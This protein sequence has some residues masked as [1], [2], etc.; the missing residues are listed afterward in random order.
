MISMI[1]E[2]NI[3]MK[4]LIKE[5]II[6]I[7]EPFRSLSDLGWLARSNF[8]SDRAS[9]DYQAVFDNKN[10]L[11]TVCIATYNR[12]ELLIER[13]LKS[14]IN[15]DYKN[16]QIVVVGDCCTDDTV[17]RMSKINDKRVEFVNLPERGSYP[18]EPRLRWMV[19]GTAAVNHALSMARGDFITHLDDDDEQPH[20]RISKLVAFARDKRADI[21][22][23]PFRYEKVPD[24]WH[25][26]SA[27]KFAV[28]QVTTSS[29]FYHR[30]FRSIPWDIRA[31]RY[32]EPGDWNRL[33]KFRYLGVRAER[34]PDVLLSHYRERNQKNKSGSN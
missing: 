22:W 5:S 9:E 28:N 20:D 18:E 27:P 6:R 4:K 33:R 2:N 13:S 3:S 21:I 10:P 16:L 11:V 12:G 31:W 23:H 7:K 8:R 26:N 24:D 25:I 19:A 14:I 17:D 30:W 15:Q 32:N 1:I 29:I 34:H